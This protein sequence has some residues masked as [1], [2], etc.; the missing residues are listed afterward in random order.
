[1]TCGFGSGRKGGGGGVDNRHVG[2]FS[3][4]QKYLYPFLPI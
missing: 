4:I 2:A 1:M 3:K